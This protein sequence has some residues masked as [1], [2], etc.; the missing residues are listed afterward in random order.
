MPK[1]KNIRGIPHNLASSYLSTM[2]YYSDGYVADWL[3]RTF[4]KLNIKEI[5]IDILRDM[6]YL[7]EV[8]INAL[9][10]YLSKLRDILEKE[11]EKNDFPERFYS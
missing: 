8:H 1:T 10:S 11:L 7:K 5:K 4:E 2:G 6:V 3:N 9:V